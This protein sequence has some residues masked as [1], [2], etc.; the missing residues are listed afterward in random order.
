MTADPELFFPLPNDSRSAQ[1]AIQV[2]DSCPVKA[3]CLEEALKQSEQ[4]GI[5]GGMT[6]E[7][8]RELLRKRTRQIRLQ[9]YAR[10]H[11]QN[12][13]YRNIFGKDLIWN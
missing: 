3:E 6:V 4:F 2:C 11:N 13:D 5:W 8:R 12:K 9:E 1:L 10:R 7:Q